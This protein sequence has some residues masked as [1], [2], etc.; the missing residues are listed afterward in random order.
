MRRLALGFLLLFALLVLLDGCSTTLVESL[1]VGNMT[2]CDPAWPGRWTGVEHGV[3]KSAVEEI[4]Q[5]NADC[6]QFTFTDPEKTQTEPHTLRLISTRAGD[7]LT[8]A[9]PGDAPKAC[10]GDGNTHCGTELFRYVH[11]GDRI[12]L[13]KP[14]H[15]RVHDALE[16]H[17]ISGYTE[18]SVDPQTTSVNGTQTGRGAV[19]DALIQ[20]R[21]AAQ[22]DKKSPTYHNLIAGDA[23]QIT[24]I[25]KQHPEFFEEEPYLILQ[26]EGPMNP[27]P[28]R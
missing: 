18:M 7:F 19:P 22:D 5:I 23:D 25:L 21:T 1:P 2:Q 11:T 14:D 26:R 24:Q 13:Y 20:A 27:T 28:D 10:F 8:F 17:A 3:G 12:I 6:T 16:S 4:V 15:K 9:S